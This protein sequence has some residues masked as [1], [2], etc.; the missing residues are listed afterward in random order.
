MSYDQR[1][2]VLTADLKA[3]INLQ[4]KVSPVDF[5]VL[6][7]SFSGQDQFGIDLLKQCVIA[8]PKEFVRNLVC[9]LP[10]RMVEHEILAQLQAG[11]KLDKNVDDDADTFGHAFTMVQAQLARSNI[12][13]DCRTIYQHALTQVD[14]F[15]DDLINGKL[16]GVYDLSSKEQ[17]ALKSFYNEIATKEPWSTN[18]EVLKSICVQRGMALIYANR[19]RDMIEPV[20]SEAIDQL[21]HAGKLQ[22]LDYVAKEESMAIF[23][24][25]GVA[26]GKGTCLKN[27]AATIKKREP[28]GI[29]WNQL[30]H[31]NADRLKP[32]LQKPE[33]DP[34]KYS[35][36]TYEEA[37]LVKERVMQHIAKKGNEAGNK[38]PHFLH[39]QTK[40]KPDELREANQ[41]YGTVVITAI[42]TEVSSSVQWAFG[43]GESTKRF[44]HTEG[45]LGSHQA[46]P[47]EMMKSLNQNELIGSSNISVAMYDNNSP[48]R[49][50]TMFASIDM[51]KKEII[52]YD[53]EMMQKWIK[54]ENI[55]PKAKPNEP[56]YFDKPTPTTSE[57]FAPLIN[58]EFSFRIIKEL[59]KGKDVQYT[60]M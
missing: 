60:N 2:F 12:V 44:E 8:Y 11:I 23:T 58:K 59:N 29:E 15:I 56:L 10:E 7:S 37:L 9:L 38:Y 33:L 30:V 5:T 21:C 18:Q 41:R 14:I 54:K 57:Y 49:E 25:G 26:S 48:T 51:K 3:R 31:H 47:G 28:I 42:S 34:Q 36:Y 50:L 40:L 24:T 45:L 32:F 1:F 6:T 35:Q 13:Q 4:E 43:R 46:V 20:V 19:A 27:T 22:P 39:D 55:N 17:E 53:E 16:D 52:V